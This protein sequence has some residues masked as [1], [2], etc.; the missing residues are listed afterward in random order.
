[1]VFPP[2]LEPPP[3]PPHAAAVRATA[4][5]VSTPRTARV[6]LRIVF[7]P[8]FSATGRPK[9]NAEKWS[10]EPVVL[11]LRPGEHRVDLRHRRLL[12]CLCLTRVGEV[13][14][15]RRRVAERRPYRV[16]ICAHRAQV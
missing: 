13:E 3:E 15:P 12:E 10:V 5:A 11:P 6:G 2:E 14:K 4:P 9:L 16:R 7:R 8:S 1:M